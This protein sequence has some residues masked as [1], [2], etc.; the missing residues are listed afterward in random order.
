MLVRRLIRALLIVA[1]I[2]AL[3]VACVA[4]LFLRELTQPAGESTIAQDFII[5]PSESLAVISSNLESEGLVR[6]AIVFRVFADL[7]NAETD[8]YP[9]TYKIS[10]NMTINQILEM[11]RVAPEVQTAVRFTVPEGLRIEEI[12]AVIESTGVVS[13]DD[14]LAV[15]SN[16][17]QFKADYSFLSSLPDSAS[18]EGYLFPDTYDIFSD[19]T[20]E[21]IVRKMLDTF[22]IRWADS[23]LSSATTGRSVHE[24]VTLA[25]IV[26]REASNNE[27]M[28]RIAAAFWNR[29]KPEFAGNQLGADPTIQYILGQPGNWWPKLDQLTIEQINSAAGPYNTRVNPGLPPGPISAPGLFALQAAASPADEDVTYFVTK[30]VAAGERPT[31]NFTND[32]SEFLQFQEEFLACPK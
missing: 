12:A 14:F 28:P 30:C 32:Y 16:G 22:A 26:Q 23:P 6:R 17:S 10:P 29:L 2:G 13:A 8:L 21:E 15:A 1:T 18:L 7:R 3:V 27:E 9:G 25:S 11:F 24:V 5:A 19:A 20:S 4:T 31:H